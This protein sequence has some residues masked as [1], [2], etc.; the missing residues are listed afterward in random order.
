VL[1]KGQSTLDDERVQVGDDAADATWIWQE[2]RSPVVRLEANLEYWDVDRGPR[3]AAVE[4]RN[5]VSAAD[6]L[7]LICTTE[8]EID[9]LTEVAPA[10]A[11]RVE[12]SKYAILV[13]AEAFRV[14]VG[15]ID[16]Y[17][18]GM[19]LADVRGRLALNLAI[20]RERLCASVMYG[21]AT[22]LAALLPSPGTP[23]SD[24]LQPYQMNAMRATTL[25]HGAGGATRTLRFAAEATY[26]D[27]ARAVAS[28]VTTA[29]GV[30]TTVTVLSAEEA[31]DARRALA[32]RRTSGWDVLI[33]E[34]SPQS[35]DG[36]PLELHRAFIGKSG[37]YRTG[38]VVP[39]F[40]RLYAELV[41]ETDEL[42]QKKI[43]ATI[44]ELVYDQALALFLYAPAALYAVNRHVTF[45]P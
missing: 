33:W 29:L 32:E 27:T 14:V 30:E 43:V 41:A 9:I 22:P 4:F 15:I 10:D 1:A 39:E 16:R 45:I 24:V 31:Q 42:E 3:L 44:D 17:A 36:P 26:V 13:T 7:E 11:Q 25:W 18:E 2:R 37:E 8:G 21:R 20:D 5:D 40:E 35:I 38:P 28:D 23:A 19:P 12:D 34:Q 6:A